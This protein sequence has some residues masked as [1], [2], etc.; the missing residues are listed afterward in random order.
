MCMH[1]VFDR[2]WVQ[3]ECFR[4]AGELA[5]S[6][7]VQANPQKSGPGSSKVFERLLPARISGLPRTVA[8]YRTV[9]DCGG[10]VDVWNPGTVAP[11]RREVRI[12]R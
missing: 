9:N 7:L 8:I 10:S 11:L 5:F 6:R 12:G 4:N 2:E 1:G 3:I